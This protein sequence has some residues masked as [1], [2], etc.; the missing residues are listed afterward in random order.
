MA[1]ALLQTEELA[2]T[3]V[4]LMIADRADLQ[5]HGV[6]RFDGRLVVEERRDERRRADQIACGNDNRI[7]VL[8]NG[9][10]QVCGEI[11]GASGGRVADDTVR[12]RGWL[13]VA[14]K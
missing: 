11:L 12:A 14:V 2:P 9:P 5:A 3:L 13:Q 6:H 8:P 7:R 4:E 10:L 1:A